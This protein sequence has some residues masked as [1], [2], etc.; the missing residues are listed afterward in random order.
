MF[1]DDKS[2]SAQLLDDYTKYTD[3]DGT[4]TCTSAQLPE[5]WASSNVSIKWSAKKH[6]GLFS[7]HE[8]QN[9]ILEFLA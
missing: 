5:A 4:I 8:I 7:S 1:W 9:T 2:S 3:G 6:L